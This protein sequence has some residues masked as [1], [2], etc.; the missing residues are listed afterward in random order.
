MNRDEALR[1]ARQ[2][3]AK[4]DGL[5]RYRAHALPAKLYEMWGDNDIA[6][7]EEE[8]FKVLDLNRD[9]KKGIIRKDSHLKK[10]LAKIFDADPEDFEAE[11]EPEPATVRER[12]DDARLLAELN[13]LG[14]PPREWNHEQARKIFHGLG[15]GLDEREFRLLLGPVY[16]HAKDALRHPLKDPTDFGV[17]LKYGNPMR[18]LLGRWLPDYLTEHHHKEVN[19]DNV[20]D[21]AVAVMAHY[22]GLDVTPEEFFD[23]F[24]FYQEWPD[25]A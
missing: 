8:L 13:A 17:A 2:H 5:F 25:A 3:L 10:E 16:R 11:E 6:I 21:Y 7:S 19:K 24:K 18:Y 20:A 12:L 15:N 1:I 14:A 4:Q 23:A 9:R 22:W